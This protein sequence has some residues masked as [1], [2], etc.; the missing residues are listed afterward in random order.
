MVPVF[1]GNR[2]TGLA[3]SFAPAASPWLRRRLSPWPSHRHRKP[4]TKSAALKRPCAAP[5]PIS[6]RFEPVPRL[7]SFTTDSSSYTVRSCL[8]DP[9]RLA[10]PNRPGFVSAASRPARRLPDQTALSSHPAA[11]TAWRGGLAPPSIPSA[12]RRTSASWRTT[13]SSASLDASRRASTIMQPSRQHASKYTTE[14]I[15]QR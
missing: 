4:A 12:S 6:T 15:T 10:V 8:P 2:L 14:K 5:R 7:R 1:T 3:S 9:A 11:A 13:R